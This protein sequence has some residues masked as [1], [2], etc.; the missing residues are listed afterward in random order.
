MRVGIVGCGGM[1]GVHANKYAQM[2]GVQMSAYDLD[3]G[4]LDAFC[5]SRNV[6]KASSMSEILDSCDAV[7]ICLPTPFHCD[8]AIA[9]L[10]AGKPTLVEKPFARTVGECETMISVADE[11]GALLVPAHVVR[12]FPEFKAANRLISRGDIGKPASVRLRR[13]GGAPRSEWFFDLDKSGGILLDLAVHEFDWLLW[14]IGPVVSVS[15]RSVRLGGRNEGREIVG[16]YALTTLSFANGCVAHVESTWMDPGGSRVTLEAS[17][18]KGLIEFDSRENPTLRVNTK[19]PALENN[20]IATDDPYFN[21]LKSFL[22]AAK[23]ESTPAVTARDGLAAVRVATA[24]IES[25]KTGH[26]VHLSA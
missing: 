3:E 26:L 2:P 5:S 18:D 25:A 24:A 19:T 20:Y 1:G 11:S 22:A 23:G 13:G 10:Q 21:Q 12:F 7:D 16:D 14:T 8:A 15:S 4:R 17:G 9:S 6:T